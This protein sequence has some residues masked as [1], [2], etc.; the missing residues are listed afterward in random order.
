MTSVLRVVSAAA[1]VGTILP[2]A[3][4]FGGS[5]DLGATKTWMLL[6]TVAWFAATPFWMW[7]K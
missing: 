3:L 1:L 5:M 7:K 4:Y 6:S 2:P